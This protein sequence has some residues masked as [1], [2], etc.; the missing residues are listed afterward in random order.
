[1]KEKSFQWIL[2]CLL[3]GVLVFIGALSN[4]SANARDLPVLVP[5]KALDK[6]Y[7][8]K[9]VSFFGHAKKVSGF[10]GRMGGRYSKVEISDQDESIDVYAAFPLINVVGNAIIVQGVYHHTGRFGGLPLDHF[11]VAEAVERDW[12]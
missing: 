7:D 9:R 1:M 5:I 4:C 2:F 11:V 8:N 12:S 3:I 10:S 6:S